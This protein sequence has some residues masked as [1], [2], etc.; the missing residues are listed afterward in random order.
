MTPNQLR[1]L[2]IIASSTPS[3]QAAVD[4]TNAEL[5][6]A[7]LVHDVLGRLVLTD[8]GNA[9]VSHVAGLGLPEQVTVWQVAAANFAYAQAN[10]TIK[11]AQLPTLAAAADGP[12]PPPA[13]PMKRL[14]GIDVPTDPA[15][16]RDLGIRLMNNGM[17]VGEVAE[18]LGVTFDEA[19]S[20]FRSQ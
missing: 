6:G 8:R 9:F 5:A 15:A 3:D 7:G 16:K 12:A 20:Y 18:L 2:F 10:P 11:P 4:F 14:N 19:D 17:G 1:Q 13:P